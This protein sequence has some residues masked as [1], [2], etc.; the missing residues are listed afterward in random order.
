[1]IINTGM[2]TDIPAFYSEWFQNRLRE[3][4]VMVR[5]PYDPNSVTRYE[6]DPNVVDIM[7][8]CT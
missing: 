4:F 6:L 8:F 3:G 2:R 5:S 1:M 7:V